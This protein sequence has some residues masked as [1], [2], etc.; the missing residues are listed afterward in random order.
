MKRMEQVAYISAIEVIGD[1]K[2]RFT[3]ADGSERDIDFWPTI[4]QGGY[5]RLR[6]R[7]Y[8]AS[9]RFDKKSDTI[10]WAD[11]SDHLHGEMLFEHWR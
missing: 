10:V 1:Y 9:V 11:D 4:K 8:F 6:D 5:D 2:I 3:F 7:A